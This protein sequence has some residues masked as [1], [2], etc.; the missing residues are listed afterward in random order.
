MGPQ[1][2][3]NGNPDPVDPP[4]QILKVAL[5]IGDY[6]K[7]VSYF[8]DAV[9]LKNI[10]RFL[11]KS[12]TSFPPIIVYIPHAINTYSANTLLWHTLLKF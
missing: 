4:N 2:P 10:R 1:T 11:W 7:I 3:L 8:C 6:F 5:S 12:R 9:R